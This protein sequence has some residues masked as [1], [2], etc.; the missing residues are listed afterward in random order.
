M[1]VQQ[2]MTPEQADIEVIVHFLAWKRGDAELVT[3]AVRELTGRPPL[4]L[5]EWLRQHQAAFV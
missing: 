2:G 1:L 5:D 3:N 4:R